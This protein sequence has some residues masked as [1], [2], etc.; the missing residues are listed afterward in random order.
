MK[1][2]FI[3]FAV[4]FT[5]TMASMASP[6]QDAIQKRMKTVLEAS[7]KAHKAGNIPLYDRLTAEYRAL[8]AQ[9][10][11]LMAQEAAAKKKKG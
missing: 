3:G 8:M 7:Q 5:I 10:T 6:A 4:L 9:A 11:A 2:A 1:I